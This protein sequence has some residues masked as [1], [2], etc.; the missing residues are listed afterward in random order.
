MNSLV[1]RKLTADDVELDELRDLI[2]SEAA[3][4]GISVFKATSYPEL[5]RKLFVAHHAAQAVLREQ[6]ERDLDDLLTVIMTKRKR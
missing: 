6:H 3:A 5:L 4:V 1:T 2:A